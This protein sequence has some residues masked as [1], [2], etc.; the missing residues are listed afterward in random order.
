MNNLESKIN[1][2]YVKYGLAYDGPPRH[3]SSE[4][5]MYRISCMREEIEEYNEAWSMTDQYD[6]LIDLLVFTVGSLYRHGFPV[7]EGFDAV[8]ACNLQK[9]PGNNPHKK[10]KDRAEYKGIDLVKP[11][12]WLGPEDKLIQILVERSAWKKEQEFQ[13]SIANPVAMVNV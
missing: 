11:A 5:K 13:R 6:A 8:M 2:A 10:D 9:V 1:E 12:G 3:L 4:E 7:Q